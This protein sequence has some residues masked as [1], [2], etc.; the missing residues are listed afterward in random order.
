LAVD[1]LLEADEWDAT[2][3]LDV[4]WDAIENVVTHARLCA[5]V[6]NIH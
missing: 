3:T 6:A 1:V 2:V 5:A 4:L